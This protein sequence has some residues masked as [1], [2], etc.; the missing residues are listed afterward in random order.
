V[1]VVVTEW[2]MTNRSSRYDR[3]R[4]HV[5]G[6]K[7]FE[8]KLQKSFVWFV[9]FSAIN[10]ILY[11]AMSV[12]FRRAFGRTLSCGKQKSDSA[13]WGYT[14]RATTTTY[15]CASSGLPSSTTLAYNTNFNARRG[16]SPGLESTSSSSSSKRLKSCLIQAPPSPPKG[17]VHIPLRRKPATFTSVDIVVDSSDAIR[18]CRIDG[19]ETDQLVDQEEITQL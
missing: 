16:T 13:Y 14:T 19:D 9:G 4:Q 6:C 1:T 2:E 7:S 17:V 15:T 10:P 11:N 18:P 12:K 5:W 3:R 8:R